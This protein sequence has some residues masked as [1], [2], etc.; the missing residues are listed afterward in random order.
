MLQASAEQKALRDREKKKVLPFQRKVSGDP[1]S[2]RGFN[3]TVTSP[4]GA[5]L[6]AET[7][8]LP[9]LCRAL[10]FVHTRT[11]HEQPRAPRWC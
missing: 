6:R 4:P 9:A 11:S 1:D 7:Q 5:V 10:A 3:Q 8:S 2:E